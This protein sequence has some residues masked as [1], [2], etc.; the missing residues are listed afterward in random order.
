VL[1]TLPSKQGIQI[2]LR[3]PFGGNKYNN[4]NK[5]KIQELDKIN[6]KISKTPVISK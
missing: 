6:E 5:K 2:V 4:N 1:R 3:E